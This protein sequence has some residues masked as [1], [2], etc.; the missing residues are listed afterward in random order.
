MIIGSW[1]ERTV[2]NMSQW[3]HDRSVVETEDFDMLTAHPYGL[4]W[5]HVRLVVETM[6]LLAPDMPMAEL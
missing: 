6:N 2:I 4:Q 5:G 1:P 3:G